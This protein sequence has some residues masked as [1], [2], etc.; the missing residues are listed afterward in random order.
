[1]TEA[2]LLSGRCRR[3]RAPPCIALISPLSRSFAP[4]QSIVRRQHCLPLP[5]LRFALYPDGVCEIRERAVVPR[6]SC[7]RGC[8]IAAVF[9]DRPCLRPPPPVRLDVSAAAGLDL[10]AAACRLPP[11]AAAAATHIPRAG[12]CCPGTGRSARRGSED[13]VSDAAFGTAN[14]E[15]CQ[16]RGRRPHRFA[17]RDD[18][19]VTLK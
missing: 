14:N 18:V 9:L 3:T 13:A 1:V 15:D 19:T 2:T 16:D 7:V 4:L 17:L 6:R 10:L 8:R 12:A 11:A 5:V